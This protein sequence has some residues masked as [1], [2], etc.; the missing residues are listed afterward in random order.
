MNKKQEFEYYLSISKNKFGIYLL[1]TKNFENLFK[2]E[3]VIAENSNTYDFNIL[4]K[5]LDKNIFKIEKLSGKFIEN[6]FLIFEDKKILN[7]EMGIKKT[8][9]NPSITKEYLQNSLIEAKDLFRKNYP[10][11]EIMHMIIKKYFVNDKSYLSFEE[12][13]ISDYLALE[14]QFKSISN[15]I[16]YDL[17]RILENYQIKIIKYLDGSYVKNFINTDI[18]LSEKSHRILNGHNQNEV[19]FVPKNIKKLAFFEKFFQLFS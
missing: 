6:I 10:N 13:L 8:N 4:K 15:S 17:N 9:Y 7:L 16:V 2:E 12:N 1:D 5:F 14:I 19:L 18:E 3:L 11:Q